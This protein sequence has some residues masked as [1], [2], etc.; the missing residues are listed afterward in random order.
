MKYKLKIGQTKSVVVD[1]DEYDVL[2]IAVDARAT[3]GHDT[4]RLVAS[5][6][7]GVLAVYGSSTDSAS[8][9]SAAG[10]AVRRVLQHAATRRQLRRGELE[11]HAANAA[12]VASNRASE[13]P[14]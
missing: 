1:G 6:T 5:P 9:D 11:V 2:D 14:A 4:M 13:D 3:G 10:E 7:G 12:M 8:L